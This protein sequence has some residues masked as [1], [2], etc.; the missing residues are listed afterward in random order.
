M[1]WTKAL[2][3]LRSRRGLRPLPES[4]LFGVA[5]ADHQCEAYDA[6]REDIRDVWE[7]QRGL[8]MR[9]CATDF[10]RRYPE[11][12]ELARKLGCTAFRFSIAWSRVEPVPGQFDEDVVGSR[13]HLSVPWHDTLTAGTAYSQPYTEE[14]QGTT[15]PFGYVSKAQAG[16]TLLDIGL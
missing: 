14:L 1:N 4:F 11:D 6:Q 8:T 3:M 9:S 12:V 10:Q 5:T 16:Q 13:S 7:R 15:H 2:T